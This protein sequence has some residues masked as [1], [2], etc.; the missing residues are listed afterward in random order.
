MKKT[1][2]KQPTTAPLATAIAQ[3]RIGISAKIVIIEQNIEQAAKYYRLTP[4]QVTALRDAVRVDAVK[5]RPSL[6]PATAFPGLD[7]WRCDPANIFRQQI[8]PRH[9]ELRQERCASDRYGVRRE[10]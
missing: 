5:D 2:R 8:G 1:L 10:R 4:D 9:R 3:C 6:R 7:D